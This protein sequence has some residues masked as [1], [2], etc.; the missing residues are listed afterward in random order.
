M[1]TATLVYVSSTGEDMKWSSSWHCGKEEQT[2]YQRG[3]MLP[4]AHFCSSSLHISHRGC[5]CIWCRNPAYWK[6]ANHHRRH[7]LWCFCHWDNIYSHLQWVSLLRIFRSFPAIRRDHM[8][9]PSGILILTIPP[10]KRRLA[11]D[12]TFTDRNEYVDA[13]PDD[14]FLRTID[15]S[16]VSL[17]S[18]QH[19][20]QWKAQ[21]NA[22]YEPMHMPAR[23]T[24]VSSE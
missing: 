2:K 10:W 19:K 23:R 17:K 6:H 3:Y 12:D 1:S 7:C 11:S 21:V 4:W 13:T 14:A 22:E 8:V 20:H 18:S 5:I 24:F 9:F 16:L 15:Q